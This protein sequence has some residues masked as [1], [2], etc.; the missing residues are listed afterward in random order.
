MDIRAS[1]ELAANGVAASVAVV[2]T[3]TLARIGCLERVVGAVFFGRSRAWPDSAAEH[4][5]TSGTG[6]CYQASSIT[7]AKHVGS[8][9]LSAQR[10]LVMSRRPHVAMQANRER[11]LQAHVRLRP[12]VV[13]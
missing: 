3:S 12:L 13:L 10:V 5:H 11:L 9:V 7:G 2:D 8:I 4:I 6:S 1:L